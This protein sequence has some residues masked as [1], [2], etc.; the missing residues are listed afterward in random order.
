[1]EMR[2]SSSDARNTG[3]SA[4]FAT[5]ETRAESPIIRS[6]NIARTFV[7]SCFANNLIVVRSVGILLNLSEASR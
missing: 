1:M 5:G 6:E 7:C 3:P 4:R 2:V